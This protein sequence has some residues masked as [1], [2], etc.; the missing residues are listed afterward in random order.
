MQA[1]IMAGGKG[2]RLSQITKD[3]IPKPMVS[4][5]GKPLLE[6]QIEKLKENKIKNFRVLWRWK[7]IWSFY[8]LYRRKRATWHSR[9]FLLFKRKNKRGIFFISIWRCIF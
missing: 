9:G 1:V 7:K 3:E 8:F 2:T 5:L 4:I 6:W